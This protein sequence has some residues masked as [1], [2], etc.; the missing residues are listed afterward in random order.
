M[1]KAKIIATIGPVSCTLSVLVD[2]IEA[3][4]DVARVNMSHGS[5][6]EHLT[7]VENIRAASRKT[8]KEIAVLIDLQGP[9]IRVDAL[10]KP[11]ALKQGDIWP[12]GHPMPC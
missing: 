10:E 8:K 12:W 2:L 6:Q 9:K 3:G 11:L 5:H 4:I 7:T 1:R